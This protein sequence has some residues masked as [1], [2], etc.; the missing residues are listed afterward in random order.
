MNNLQLSFFSTLIARF[1]KQELLPLGG[2][3]SAMRHQRLMRAIAS[4]H[5]PLERSTAADLFDI[6]ADLPEPPADCDCEECVLRRKE[7]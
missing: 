6:S 5:A 4:E 7:A 2:T 1:A 3:L